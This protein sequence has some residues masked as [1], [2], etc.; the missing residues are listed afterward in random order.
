MS[1]N[2]DG[3]K[4]M[5]SEDREL[6]E[7]L[8]FSAAQEQ[9]RARRWSI[10]F[11]FLFFI[12][13]FA[14]I[15]SVAFSLKGGK[16]APSE[17]VA[18]ID[19]SGPIAAGKPASADT[20]VT[21]LRRAFEDEKVKGVILRINS[22]GGS[23][24]QASYVYDEVNRLK[25]TRDDLKVYG[26]I[27]DVGAS[28][29][30]YMAAATDE[31]YADRG[32]VVGSIGAYMA[33]FGFEG[34]MEK[35]GVTRRFY[36]SGEHKSLSDPFQP[37]DPEIAQHLRG[38]VRNIHEQ[39]IEKVKEGRGDRLKDDPEIFSGLIWTG[40]QALELGLVDGLGSSGYVARE[41]IG[42][43]EIVDFTSKPS[44]VER[45]AR[46]IGASAAETLGVQLGL[47]GPV[48]R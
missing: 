23:P 41:V 22:P 10:F 34:V 39:F 11:R 4:S 3:G 20:I 31:I 6:I 12:W 18:L 29:A 13:L 27:A 8:L 37:E 33:T 42:V 19:I 26:V 1:D 5:A 32:S 28:A 35:V 25:A 24:V 9:R 44:V 14:A 16:P 15:A 40:Q 43:E 45:F 38:T 21:G 47:E 30:Y 36:A 46:Q 17:Y 7:K 48:V 2:Q